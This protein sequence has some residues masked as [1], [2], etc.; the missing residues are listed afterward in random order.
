MSTSSSCIRIKDFFG[1]GKI[2]NI[3]LA[4]GEK[5]DTNKFLTDFAKLIDSMGCKDFYEAIAKM[6]RQL[7]HS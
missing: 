3:Y 4:N 2:E 5:L 6:I 1:K 7:T